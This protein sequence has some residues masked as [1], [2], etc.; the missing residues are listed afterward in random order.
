MFRSYC[1]HQTYNSEYPQYHHPN[2]RQTL[3]LSSSAP[4]QQEQPPAPSNHHRQSRHQRGNIATMSSF[5]K[6]ITNRLLTSKLEV[7]RKFVPT[8]ALRKLA[9][10]PPNG[11]RLFLPSASNSPRTLIT[12]LS[13]KRVSDKYYDRN[14]QLEGRGI[15]VRWRKEQTTKH[16]GN[17]AEPSQGV[18]EA[19][20]QQGG[21]FVN[22]KFVELKGRDAIEE[23]M[24]NAGVCD[25]IYDI[26]YQMGFMADRVS[27]SVQS[28]DGKQSH[29]DEAAMT[30]VLD[31][32]IAS[33]EGAD[34]GHPKNFHHEIGEL[35]L[36]KTVTTQ[37]NG[38]ADGDGALVRKH[39]SAR[40]AEGDRM[41]EELAAFMKARPEVFA[42][43][44]V[45]LG[46]LTAYVKYKK[47][48]AERAWK[49]NEGGRIASM[50][51]I[52]WEREYNG[53]G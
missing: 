18:W 3:A 10:E 34:G 30:I 22:S 17:D 38:T 39:D 7:E 19:K 31:T 20:V 47:D 49:A 6:A 28:L 36:A 13:R 4:P 35:E 26:K 8:P 23:L 12:R 29:D 1:H 5:N 32:I 25:S 51:E 48:Q 43:D 40:V 2:S 9:S 24:S 53:K 16:D 37:L 14:G 42:G 52:K 33:L 15:W 50:S 46:K 21:D 11:S 41:D 44:G 27:W 45:P